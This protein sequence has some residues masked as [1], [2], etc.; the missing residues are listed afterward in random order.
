MS[1]KFLGKLNNFS[2]KEERAFENKHLKAYL[3]GIKQFTFGKDE[4]GKP[5]VFD[6]LESND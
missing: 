3:K 5:K 1:R 4:T 6:V 2:S